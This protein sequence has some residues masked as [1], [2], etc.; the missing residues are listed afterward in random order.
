MKIDLH[1]HTRKIKRGDSEK[2]EITPERF[3]QIVLE[4][5]VKIVAITNHNYFDKEQF[6]QIINLSNNNYLV[7]PG[8]EIDILDKSNRG[9]VIII[10]NPKNEKRFYEITE[11]ML[12]EKD[13]ENF[14]ID[15][16]QLYDYFGNEDVIYIF[17]YKKKPQLEI[18]Q[19][20]NFESRIEERYRVF[21]EATE[22]RKMGIL[23]N[24]G[25]NSILGSDVKDWDNY[26]SNEIPTLKLEVNSFEQFL[27]LAKKDSSTVETL[28]SKKN[29]VEIDCKFQSKKEQMIPLY[30]DINIIFGAK[31]S[32]KS[33]CLEIINEFFV[34]K[35]KN[36][37]FYEANKASETYNKKFKVTKEERKLENYKIDLCENE[38]EF[39]RN[40]E[41]VEIKPIKNYIEHYETKDKAQI[42][43]IIQIAEITTSQDE[44][45]EINNI[46][47]S[48]DKFKEIK[49]SYEKYI[50]KYMDESNKELFEK[51]I[52]DTTLKLNKKRREIFIKEKSKL[53]VKNTIN[54]FKSLIDIN[55]ETKSKPISCNF[56]EFCINKLR[57]KIATQ[58]II[59][60]MNS[61]T[62]KKYE[63][64]GNLENS[65]NVYLCIRYQMLK[66]SSKTDEFE[67]GIRKL[68]QF[69]TI[70]NNIDK[71]IFNDN[72]YKKISEIKDE[73]LKHIKSL[74]QFVGIQ[75]KPVL[76]KGERYI[77]YKPSTGEE[78]MLILQE[79]LESDKDIF[80]LD[81]PEKSLGN[82]YISDVI[83][84]ILNNLAKERKMVIIATHNANIAVRTLPY[85]SIYKEYDG[86]YRTFI[87][88]PFTNMLLNIED[89]TDMK[90]WKETSLKCLEGGDV[91]FDERGEIY[92]KK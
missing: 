40:W 21:Y 19:I 8:I 86:K 36:V 77:N 62:V 70:I 50:Q 43:K 6:D 68:R 15:L 20:R 45:D 51:F 12:Y 59:K 67:D 65:K 66:S 84:P 53:L 33:K 57:L 13:Y 55:T 3:N 27:L 37:I 18:E 49:V 24:Q 46:K 7:W 91:A 23:T 41:D 83:V 90:D 17:H 34:K 47:T 72:L 42:R 32:G 76:K 75:K 61:E 58:S 48:I 14:S 44:T 54:T 39:I 22:I 1:C 11:K 10:A 80:I 2:R 4:N 82:T 85:S 64:L 63:K 79:T 56:K 81:E 74:K 5:D 60:N 25:Y 73:E 52:D 89:N 30:D 69:S 31:G 92:G 29:R 38:I 87:G 35:G 9:H 88:N 28:L 26:N 78:T 16:N 71:S